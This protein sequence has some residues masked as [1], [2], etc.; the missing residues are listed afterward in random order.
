VGG[1]LGR[2]A[3]WFAAI[4]LLTAAVDRAAAA[5]LSRRGV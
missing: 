5:R 1:I 2:Q 4:A 3:A